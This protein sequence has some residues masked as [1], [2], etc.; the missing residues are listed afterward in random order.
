MAQALE[1]DRNEFQFQPYNL[2]DVNLDM[3]LKLSKPQIPQMQNGN[4]TNLQDC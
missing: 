3:S 2:W 1:S 4:Y